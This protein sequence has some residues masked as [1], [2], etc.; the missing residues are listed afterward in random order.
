MTIHLI[1]II[2]GGLLLTGALRSLMSL[3]RFIKDAEKAVGT[4]TK[5][6]EKEDDDGISYYPVFDIPTRHHGIITYGAGTGTSSRKW[7]IGKTALF[8][9]KPDKPETTRRLNFWGIFWWPLSLMAI[10]VDLLLIGIGY[11]LLRGYLVI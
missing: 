4:V 10:G 6:V 3:R 5:L 8:I 7:E 1:F 11:F 2:V 9:L